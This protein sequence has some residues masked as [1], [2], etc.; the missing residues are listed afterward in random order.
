MSGQVNVI[1]C[2]ARVTSRKIT[3]CILFIHH[4]LHL[5]TLRQV[6]FS[7]PI[8]DLSLIYFTR[9][10]KLSE[11]EFDFLAGVCVFSYLADGT[12]VLPQIVLELLEQ[13]VQLREI[14][15]AEAKDVTRDEEYYKG[16]RELLT[17]SSF[18]A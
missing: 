14:F 7:L 18:C 6:F 2:N 11:K 12:V 1:P 9:T 10:S 17:K 5:V 4:R 8:P 3:H 15:H 13:R 16:Y